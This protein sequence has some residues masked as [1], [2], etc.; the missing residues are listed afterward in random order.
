MKVV[1]TDKEVGL[2][3][4]SEELASAILARIGLEPRKRGST[5]KMHL[6]LMELYERTKRSNREKKPEAAIMTVEEMGIFAGI[7]RQTM[8]DYLRRWTE[9]N[10]ITKMSYIKDG[11]VIIGYKLN[12]ATLESSFEKSMQVVNNNL[13][14]TR[15]YCQELQRVLKNEKISKTISMNQNTQVS[16]E[17]D[18]GL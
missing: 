18:E 17:F 15:K 2:N 9:L 6:T 13:E 1:I 12:G 8:Y 5:D 7:S 11:K 4:S 10:L 3:P 14:V 16:E